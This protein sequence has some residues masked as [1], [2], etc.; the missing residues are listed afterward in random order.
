[1]NDNELYNAVKETVELAHKEFPNLQMSMPD[2]EFFYRGTKGGSANYVEHKIKLNAVLAA[3]NGDKFLRTVKH[4]VA[5]LVAFKLYGRQ[6]WGHGHHFKH[7]FVKLGGDGKRCH[8]Y[9]V[10]N[11]KQKYTKR[12][13]EHTCSCQNKFFWVSKQKHKQ[14]MTNTKRWFCLTCKSTLTPTGRV[15]E[16]VNGNV[17]IYVGEF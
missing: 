12:R 15:K 16:V 4:E 13:H 3:E 6:A 7:V 17:Q 8:N 10:T 5:H 14:I 1:M 11:V 9:D 2:V